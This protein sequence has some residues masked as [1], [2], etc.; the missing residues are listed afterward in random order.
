MKFFIKGA[1]LNRP[2]VTLHLLDILCVFLL[3]GRCMATGHMLYYMFMYF[4]SCSFMVNV[5]TTFKA[6]QGRCMATSTGHML[7]F[8]IYYVYIVLHWA[9]M[10]GRWM[11][12]GH[13]LYYTLYCVYFILSRTTLGRLGAWLLATCCTST[14]TVTTS[15]CSKVC[16]DLTRHAKLK[17]YANSHNCALFPLPGH[18]S[19]VCWTTVCRPIIARAS[20]STDLWGWF[21]FLQNHAFNLRRSHLP[22]FASLTLR[23]SNNQYSLLHTLKWSSYNLV[24]SSC[25]S[26][27]SIVFISVFMSVM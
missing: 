13:M 7:Y 25:I 12:T 14:L 27:I 3:Q 17:F 5:Y 4:T 21:A 26:C 24:C 15:A 9:D 8:M 6:R 11:A 23:N 1:K 18:Y 2:H 16:L 22:N 19:D 20:P 10:G